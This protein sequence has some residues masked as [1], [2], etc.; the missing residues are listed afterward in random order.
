[1]ALKLSKAF[2]TSPYYWLNLQNSYD[3]WHTDSL[4][5]KK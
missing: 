1:M 3:L 5:C 2:K 4:N